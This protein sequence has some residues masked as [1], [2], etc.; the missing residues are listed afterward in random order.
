M[1]RLFDV[2]AAMLGLVKTITY[3]GQAAIRLETLAG[4]ADANKDLK[5]YSWS[6]CGHEISVSKMIE[7]VASDVI[8]ATSAS[9]IAY[10]FHLTV[11]DMVVEVCRQ[12]ASKTGA[13]RVALSGGCFQNALLSYLC[14]TR[15]RSAGLHPLTH[16]LVPPNDGGVAL[17]QAAAARLGHSPNCQHLN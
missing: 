13:K 2:I 7:T 5:P 12:A 3:E 16:R 15:L 11:A 14:E 10:R 9:E 4:R 17:G 6:L 8:A 1:G